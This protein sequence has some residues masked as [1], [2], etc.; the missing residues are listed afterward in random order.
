M[1]A[2]DQ[3]D[4][5]FWYAPVAQVQGLSVWAAEDEAG[6]TQ[7]Q[8]FGVERLQERVGEEGGEVEARAG[9][10]GDGEGWW[11]VAGIDDGADTG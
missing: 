1:V 2:G 4:G 7:T 8:C 9:G 5:V 6:D 10:W 11:E 3:H